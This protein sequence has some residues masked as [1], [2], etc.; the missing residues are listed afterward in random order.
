MVMG[1]YGN[2]M[3][4]LGWLGMSVLWLILLERHPLQAERF[5]LASA[6]GDRE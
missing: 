3:G 2:V 4:L 6:Q 5:A 1:W